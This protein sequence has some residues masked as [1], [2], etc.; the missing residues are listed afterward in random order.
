MADGVGQVGAVGVVVAWVNQRVKQPEK[1]IVCCHRNENGST[2]G[3]EFYKGIYIVKEFCKV[4][5]ALNRK[6]FHLVASGDAEEQRGW[7]GQ[8]APSRPR[9]I[10]FKSL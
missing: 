6:A 3:K 7:D 5:I 8:D 4:A 9:G 1:S 10:T 2:N